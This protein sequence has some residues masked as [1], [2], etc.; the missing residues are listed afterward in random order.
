MGEREDIGRFLGRQRADFFSPPG[1]PDFPNSRRRA[2]DHLQRPTRLRIAVTVVAFTGCAEVCDDALNS[3]W[4]R[5]MQRR[6]HHAVGVAQLAQ[7]EA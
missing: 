5:H 3:D 2:S 7:L 4:G 6:D 1:T